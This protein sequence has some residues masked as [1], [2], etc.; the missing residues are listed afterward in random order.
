MQYCL[1]Y[2]LIV[3]IILCIL[4]LISIFEY[5]GSKGDAL[6]DDENNEI[7]MAEADGRQNN[8]A[9]LELNYAELSRA[10]LL[11]PMSKLEVKKSHIHGYGLFS[12]THFDK[13][14]MIVEYIGERVRQT[15]A[16]KREIQYEDEG[17][18]SCYLFRLDK[19][20]IVDATRCGG[21][22][23]FMNHCCEPNAYA[24]IIVTHH[25]P[26]ALNYGDSN[27]NEHTM[28]NSANNII[29]SKHIVIFA[30]RDIEDGE[31]I[32]YDYKFPIETSNKLRCFCGAPK[33]VGF[34]N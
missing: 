21:M 2:Q 10:Y 1:L 5:Q 13:N 28:D 27:F 12:R 8:Q 30:A 15:V 4:N 19:D 33:C 16:D 18:G 23:R 31:E 9:V 14:D 3:F 32:T 17:V 26:N 22:A 6:K 11:N 25:T 34:M 7:D 24:R 20:E 29:E